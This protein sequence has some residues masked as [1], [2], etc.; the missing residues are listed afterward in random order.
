[1]SFD[2][3]QVAALLVE[4]K[5]DIGNMVGRCSPTFIT[6]DTNSCILLLKPSKSGDHSGCSLDQI[7]NDTHKHR[8]HRT[9][10]II[11]R[12]LMDSHL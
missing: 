3:H 12:Y 6:E 1:M 2:S 11:V 9:T 8:D 4:T 5:H 7:I 10:I